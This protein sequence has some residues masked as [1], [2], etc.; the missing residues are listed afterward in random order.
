MQGVEGACGRGRPRSGRRRWWPR[1]CPAWTTQDSAFSS[2]ALLLIFERVSPLFSS[3]DDRKRQARRVCRVHAICS[4]HLGMLT[5]AM[6]GTTML[7][8]AVPRML[9]PPKHP[10][11]SM[12]SSGTKAGLNIEV[13]C[14]VCCLF[15]P[16]RLRFWRFKYM[17]DIN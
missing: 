16:S 1:K 10:A 5:M 9:C 12:A 8:S 4:A 14:N 13:Q 11:T 17:R 6:H 2:A 7:V 3:S 15:S